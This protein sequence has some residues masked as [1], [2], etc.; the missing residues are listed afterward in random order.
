MARRFQDLVEAQWNKGHFVCVGLD[1]DYDKM[2]TKYQHCETDRTRARF[3]RLFCKHIVESTKDHVCAYKPNTAFFEAYGWQGVRMLE[4]VLG[5]IHKVAPDV[6]IILDAKRADIG[7]T[8]RGYARFAFDVLEA[9]AITVH[10]YLGSGAMMPFLERKDKCIFVLCKTS[11]PGS[12]EFQD[13]GLKDYWRNDTHSSVRLYENV[14]LTV[15]DTWNM[16]GNCGLV[17]GATYPEAIEDIRKTAGEM[18]LLIPG[19]GKQGGDLASVLKYARDSRGRGMII[20]SSSDI[21]YASAENDFAEAA[22][23]KLIALN[24]QI[25]SLL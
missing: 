9:D 18:P 20:N 19:I 1:P 2:P 13:L 3:M 21:L 8:N 4:Q 14:A 5:F 10:P 12:G 15:N 24:D 23:A 7:N 11:N 6:P 17:V 16:Q 25:S 22:R